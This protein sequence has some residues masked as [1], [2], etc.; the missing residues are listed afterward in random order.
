MT[1]KSNQSLRPKKQSQ[2]RIIKQIWWLSSM[3]TRKVELFSKNKNMQ[4]LAGD[5]IEI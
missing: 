1:F 2:G 4:F 3:C 5:P